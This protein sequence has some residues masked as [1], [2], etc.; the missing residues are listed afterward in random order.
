[1]VARR[2]RKSKSLSRKSRSLVRKSAELAIAA[3]QVISHRVA[4]IALAAPT[5]PDHDR[6]EFQMMVHEKHTAFAES[7]NAMAMQ[8][9]RTNQTLAASLF[10]FFFNPTLHPMS[11]A[12]KV[13]VHVQHAAIDV[14]SAGLAPVH[15]T[16]ISNARRLVRT[17]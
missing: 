14:L 13:A 4:R 15:R 16:A 3:P 6:K 9:I 11:S 5:L 12:A 8:I 7:W 17:A 1:M 10:R 2:I